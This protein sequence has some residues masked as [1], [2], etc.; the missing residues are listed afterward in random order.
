MNEKEQLIKIS[1]SNGK[2]DT[3]SL[4]LNCVS[5]F[6]YLISMLLN[7]TGIHLLTIEA[8]FNNSKILLTNLAAS[9][10]LLPLLQIINNFERA[11]SRQDSYSM[12]KK[13][14]AISWVFYYFAMYFLTIDRYI[15]VVFP[16]K[17]RVM[18]TTKLNATWVF[19][20]F[21]GMPFS[22]NDT[23]FALFWAYLWTVGN[24]IFILLCVLTYGMAFI[25][26]RARQRLQ[27]NQQDVNTIRRQRLVING[28]RK[29]MKVV[30][31]IICSFLSLKLI[32]DIIVHIYPQGNQ[33]FWESLIVIWATHIL[34]DP[35]IYIFLQ[36]DL[37]L[38][39][40]RKFFRI[41][42]QEQTMQQ[43]A[44]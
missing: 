16:L 41:N 34:T 32:P 28:N 20:F 18:M 13:L 35:L 40:K 39:F 11:F 30:S 42:M 12:I 31:L 10:I 5:S 26:L 36:D 21:L 14:A 4:I 25:K 3:L 9:E 27:N 24:I 23:L 7:I 44:N 22:I 1:Q 15:R 2:M 17:Y 6:I 37:R 38:L 19:A 29:F 33:L 8:P 43:E